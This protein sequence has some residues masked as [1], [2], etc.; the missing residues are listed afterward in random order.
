VPDVLIA[1]NWGELFVPT[2]SV[3]EMIVRGTIMYLGILLIFRFVAGRQ[4][5]AIGLADILVIVIIADA[6]QNAFSK[7]Y[8]SI[9]EGIILVLTIVFW[10]FVLDWLA[11][12]I[13]FFAWLTKHPPLPL[14]EDGKLNRRNMRQELISTDELRSQA[15]QQGIG[16]IE[17]IQAAYLEANGEVSFIKK[18]TSQAA[19]GKAR[20]N[21]VI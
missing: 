3:A 15:R 11:Y 13:R 18:T 21:R 10:D 4:F 17:D 5:S 14:V 12:H 1:V 8:K 9:T 19:K 7:E 20:R 16:E 6:A 2:H